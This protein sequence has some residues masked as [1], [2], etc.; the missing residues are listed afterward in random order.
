MNEIVLRDRSL[1]L[2]E[3]SF[4]GMLG[5]IGFNG[6]PQIKA[7]I[8]TRN[9]GMHEI[10]FCSNTA[11]K[12]V[13]QIKQN[14]DSSVYFVDEKTLEGL[15]LT[16][17]SEVSYDDS[18]RK[19]FWQDGMEKFYPQGATDPDYALVKF[20]AKTANYYYSLANYDFAVM[21]E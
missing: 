14:P 3:R 4:V 7:M 9:E 5:T 6:V 16:G 21:N 20:T 17:T 2:V 15:L 1:A 11:S 18:K 12:R 19:E 10:W 13:Q 8:K